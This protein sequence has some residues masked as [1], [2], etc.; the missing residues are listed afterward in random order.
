MA[1]HN[2]LRDPILGNIKEVEAKS[3]GE[4][5]IGEQNYFSFAID[6]VDK[7]WALGGNKISVR[8]EWLRSIAIEDI[9]KASISS[10]TFINQIK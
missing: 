10:K 3:F 1:E 4:Q 2:P 7:H 8:G 6:E 5:L 9:I